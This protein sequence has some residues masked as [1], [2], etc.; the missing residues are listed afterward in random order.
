MILPEDDVFIDFK[1]NCTKEEAVAKMLGWTK[2]ALRKRVI[3][4]T[5]NGIPADELPYLQIF[6]GPLEDYLIDLRNAAVDEFYKSLETD[7]PH[8][9]IV[10]KENAVKK[11]D[12]QI[13]LA[14][15]YLAGITDEL[16][17]GKLSTLRIDKEATNK[18][19][20][21]HIT[22][23]SLHDW[24]LEKYGINILGL[25]TPVA[26]VRT[27]SVSSK[28]LS[29]NAEADIGKKQNTVKKQ[30]KLLQQEEAISNEIAKQGYDAKKLPKNEKG[31]RGVKSEINAAL[32]KDTLFEGKTTFDKAW[33]R[34]R[35][36]NEIIDIQ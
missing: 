4:V 16:A 13:Q 14:G 27:A 34:L 1:T 19:G 2:G 15:T 25:S 11:C 33:Q 21:K 17:K 24:A 28:Q 23:Q 3:S 8:D 7:A 32:E 29:T 9:V 35:D 26:T 20:K 30:S 22:I 12:E 31:K 18:T 36:H 5:E 6:E 10:D